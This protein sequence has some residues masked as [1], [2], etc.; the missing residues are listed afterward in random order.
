VIHSLYTDRDIFIRE[1]V[2]NA[3]DALEKLRHV[4][5]K[6][7]S[8]FDESLPLEINITTDDT[9]KTITI[10]DFGIGMTREELGENLGTIA[11]S[12]S[13]AFLNAAQEGGSDLKESLIGQF[14]VGFYSA[15]MVAERVEVFTH[16]W[17]QDA[18]HLVWRS[19][20]GGE[21]EIEA[22]EGQR[23]GAKIVLH[24]REDAHEFAGEGRIKSLL[25]QYSNFV[26]FPINL[27]GERINK[28][29]AV[30][31]R[32]PAE[33]TE[34]EYT[35]FFKFQAHQF[36]P[37]R[38]TL[39]FRADAPLDIHAVV[40]VPERNL[41]KLGMQRLEPGVSLYCKK[42]LIDAKPEALVPEWMR[43]ARGVLDSADLPLNI[44]RERMQDSALVQKLGR[45]LVRRFLKHLA[46]EARKDE[47]KYAAFFREFGIFLKEGVATDPSNQADLA[48][49]LRFESSAFDAGEVTGFEAYIERM[50]ERQKAI[51]YLQADSREAIESGPYLEGL[52][53]QG[54]EVL[55]CT[56]PVDGIVMNNLRTFDEKP[57]QAADA[58]DAELEDVAAQAEGEPL[59]D[60]DFKQLEAFLR[61]T[62]GEQVKEVRA[63]KRLVESPLV[64]L[65]ADVMGSP[66]MRRMMRAMN[67]EGV[68][69]P[70]VDLELNARHSLI[71]ALSR[72]R[73]EN[74]SKAKLVAEAMFNS[75]LLS[76]GL[77]ED[78][79]RIAPH[80]NKILA[81]LVD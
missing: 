61:A 54:F 30:W 4:Q 70:A 46:E 24:L 75:A 15:F 35:E 13:K 39:H 10:Q 28:V 42:V 55:Y 20:G 34:E 79:Q 49:L 16:S 48:K 67:P 29:Q 3:S 32:N 27:N 40:F 17:K 7:G 50:P 26:T 11:H 1:L 64:A 45:V 23:R 33:V 73:V 59:S 22:S 72:W 21:Y 2:S 58:K 36:E 44:S 14:G 9:A 62:L 56:E 41:E 65:S 80:F 81:A 53:A 69:D 76:A 12:G 19:D 77:Y 38:S 5:L 31:L 43:F 68:G 25:E 37:P 71:H 66:S 6:G 51:Y 52:K 57:V 18:E 78:P 47:E 8:V 74:E 63:S 60:E